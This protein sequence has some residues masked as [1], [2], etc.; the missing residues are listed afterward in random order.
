MKIVVCVKYVPEN[1]DVSVDPEHGRPKW[2]S[3]TGVMNPF[4]AYAVEQGVEFKEAHGG[5]VIALA[6]GPPAAEAVIRDAVAGGADSGILVS[7]E[8]LALADSWTTALAVAKAVG[9]IGDV[10][11]V[12]CGKQAVDG[13][14]AQVGPA[15]A[16]QLGW[17]QAAFVSGIESCS[18]D[19][20]TV[21]RMQE[22]GYEV[23]ELTCPALITVVKDINSPRIPSLRSRMAAKKADI[24]V[25]S[26]ADIGM[27]GDDLVSPTRVVETR[28]PQRAER[29]TVV[30]EGEPDDCAAQ[31]LKQI[32]AFIKG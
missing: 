8:A 9:K 5:E 31:I 27:E 26:A 21:H 24:P 28:Q 16:A 1:M 2:D 10:D 4:D 23:C 17:P 19:A 13:G 22:S 14:T 11:L 7:D 30:I 3:I 15:A 12:I 18:G 25:W 20:L 6:V 29:K 32:E